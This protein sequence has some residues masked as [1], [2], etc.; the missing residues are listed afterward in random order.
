[1]A[2]ENSSAGL[3]GILRDLRSAV[4]DLF[5][6]GKLAEDRKVPVEVLFG[7][8]GYV[9]KADGIVT[10]HEAEVVNAL[11]QQMNLPSGGLAL[12]SDA[13]ERGKMRQIE[14]AGEVA[15]I[16]ALHPV[17]SPELAQLFDTLVRVAHADGRLFARERAALEEIGLA[18]GLE[19][20]DLAR[21]I[22]AGA[23]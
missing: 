8:I 2:S 18:L 20:D 9:A 12:A 3:S 14:V 7:L 15:R 4:G 17:G 21:R 22:E 1:M 5:T 19:P 13:F 10:S 16:R 23:P 11:M 6:G